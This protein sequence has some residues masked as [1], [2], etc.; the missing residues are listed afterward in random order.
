MLL[1]CY[2]TVN[3][4]KTDTYL[5]MKKK[6]ENTETDTYLRMK[7]KKE[8]TETDTYLRMKRKKENTE[9]CLGSWKAIIEWSN[10]KR[11]QYYWDG[12]YK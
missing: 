5:R 12:C 3:R 9:F 8:N 6:K 10:S 11:N 7:K 1:Y 4:R 2:K